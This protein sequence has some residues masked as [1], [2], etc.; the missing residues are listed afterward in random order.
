MVFY[1]TSL[2]KAEDSG[3]DLT[4]TQNWGT[5]VAEARDLLSTAWAQLWSV[6]PRGKRG[7]EFCDTANRHHVGENPFCPIRSLCWL[8]MKLYSNKK[9]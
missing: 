6:C 9:S 5:R 7:K 8:E 2:S 4:V 1:S 3:S